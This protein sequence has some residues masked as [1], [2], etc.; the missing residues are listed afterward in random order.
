MRRLNKLLSWLS[1]AIIG[2]TL[3]A[4]FQLAGR[5]SVGNR[6]QVLASP[7]AL[8]PTHT[9]DATQLPPTPSPPEATVSPTPAP[10][11]L[12]PPMG[13]PPFP[14]EYLTPSA[15]STPK[16]PPTPSWP[17]PTPLPTLPPGPGWGYRSE[18]MI[19]GQPE[20]FGHNLANVHGGAIWSPTGDMLAVSLQNGRIVE[21]E[22]GFWML[23]DVALI[24]KDGE[25]LKV[26]TPGSPPLAWSPDGRLIAYRGYELSPA[27]EI[28]RDFHA[29]ID[30][31]TGQM[32]EILTYGDNT[33]ITVPAWLSETQLVY[34]NQRP[35]VFNYATG[36][37]QQLL[38]PEILEQVPVR[39]PFRF[40]TSSPE[41]GIIALG[42]SK[43]VLVERSA[44]TTRVLKIIPDGLDHPEGWAISPDG[45][46]LA[47]VDSTTRL[48]KIH[49]IDND[50]LVELPAI[51]VHSVSWAPD[52]ES[53]V[54]IDNSELMIV[55]RDGSGLRRIGQS[56][57]FEPFK[58]SWS[59]RGDSVV[60]SSLK[61]DLFMATVSKHHQ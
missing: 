22:H 47:Y 25:L 5:S 9:S 53:L 46:Y 48:L 43:V 26:L 58:I 35:L 21:T 11:Q 13:T 56:L 17:T 15:I 49:G 16:V 36:Q 27:G 59:P 33:P 39:R 54:Y 23:A 30:V 42:S 32:T 2:L 31:K 60:I 28:S 6:A 4:L 20:P 55:N 7:P 10:H 40:F 1:L 34:F 14:I 24:S 44:D 12:T 8:S 19:F 37:R 50:T 18:N 29:T 41:R 38:T 45:R 51:G 57:P 52:S 61:G 3:V